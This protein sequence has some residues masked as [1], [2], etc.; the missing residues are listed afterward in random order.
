[1]SVSVY[2]VAGVTVLGRARHEPLMCAVRG[3]TGQFG[4]R[5]GG[6]A[7][8]VPTAH[9][10]PPTTSSQ[11]ARRITA[12]VS[13]RRPCSQLPCQRAGG[14]ALLCTWRGT[15]VAP[16]TAQRLSVSTAQR[17]SVSVYLSPLS[18]HMLRSLPPSSSVLQGDAAR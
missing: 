2:V 10:R 11:P 18:L 9:G 1:M 5:T 13:A 7:G 6:P 16:L 15:A 17:L 14:A 12:V 8:R 4:R 3:R